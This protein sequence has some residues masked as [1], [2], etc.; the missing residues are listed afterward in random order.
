[1]QN[2]DAPD[3]RSRLF[4]I[5][6]PILYGDVFDCPV[7]MEEIRRYCTCPLPMEEL[8]H[9]IE[10][11]KDFNRLVS[12]HG[13]FFYL[14][15]RGSLG[16]VRVRRKET[17]RKAWRKACRIVRAIK[18]I[19]FI[20]GIMATGSLAAENVRRDDDLDFLVLISGRR[21]WF[22]FFFLGTL[23]RII[24]RRNLCPNYY[25]SLDHIR[26]SRQSFYV[27][28]EAAQAR[29]LYGADCCRRFFQE[30]DWIYTIFPNLDEPESLIRQEDRIDERRGVM[31]AA[32]GM[33]ERLLS[34]R[35][36]DGIE[37]ILKKLLRHR[38]EVHYGLH[39][40]AVPGEVLRNALNEIEL[41]FHGLGHEEK[42]DARVQEKRRQLTDCLLN[43]KPVLKAGPS[44]GS[45]P[46]ASA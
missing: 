29:A 23:Q 32:S 45:R 33:V 35:L 37:N 19:P 30:N 15:G 25:I 18:Y 41:R 1:M 20:K 28:R 27:A 38:L 43:G 31:K 24:S 13:P 12:R 16:D 11:D 21:I 42:I 34:G 14:N 3:S 10:N 22:A 2:S 17:S 7:T 39:D 40:Q 44:G 5:L 6:E 4:S 9:D 8:E 26:L 46:N 36:G